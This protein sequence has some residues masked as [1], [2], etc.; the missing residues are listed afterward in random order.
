MLH[1]RLIL[2]QGDLSTYQERQAKVAT[3]KADMEVVLQENTYYLFLSHF[4]F[5]DATGRH[6]R[7]VEGGARKEREASFREE[8]R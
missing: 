1:Q 7:K 4:L 2:A 6:E 8:S 3:Q 5:L